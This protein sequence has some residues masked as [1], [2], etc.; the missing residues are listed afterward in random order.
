MS[1]SWITVDMTKRS[2]E[3][4]THIMTANRKCTLPELTSC[5]SYRLYGGGSSS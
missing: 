1:E 5:A 2:R 3:T 4:I